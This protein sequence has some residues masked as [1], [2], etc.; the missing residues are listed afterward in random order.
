MDLFCDFGLPKLLAC[1]KISPAKRPAILRLLYAFSPPDVTSHMQVGGGIP[2]PCVRV[3]ISVCLLPVQC[4]KKLQLALD[5]IPLF[6]HAVAILVTL[7][8]EFD[9]TSVDTYVPPSLV[10]V[11]ADQPR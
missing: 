1:F 5:S 11:V 7:E 2:C 9:S 6:L 3:L 8:T 4:V 10:A